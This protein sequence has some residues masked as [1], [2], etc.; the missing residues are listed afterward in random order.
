MT[1]YCPHCCQPLYNYRHGVRLSAL[2]IRIFDAIARSGY[3]GLQI[4]DIMVLCFDRPTSRSNVRIHIYQINDTLIGTN[5]RIHGKRPGMVGFYH[6]VKKP[7]T[8]FQ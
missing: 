6:L 3:E 1:K 2:K 4:E 8:R 5:L 7:D